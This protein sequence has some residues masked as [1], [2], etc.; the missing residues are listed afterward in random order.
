M[1][2]A[3]T[4]LPSPVEEA[5]RD[6]GIIVPFSVEGDRDPIHRGIIIDIGASPCESWGELQPGMVVYFTRSTRVADVEIVFHDHI[7]A[8]EESDDEST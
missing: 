8:Y 7:L 1:C 2:N 6:S 3:I 4:V 5:V